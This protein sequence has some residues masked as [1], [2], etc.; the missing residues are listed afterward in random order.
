MKC[1]HCAVEADAKKTNHIV[2]MDDCIIIVRQVPSYVCPECG[3]VM[4]T[5]SV[6]KQIEQYVDAAKSAMSDLSVINYQNLIA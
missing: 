6:A 5:A 2:D 3:E 1:Y 4:Y